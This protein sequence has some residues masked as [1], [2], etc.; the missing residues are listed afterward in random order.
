[1][2]ERHDFFLCTLCINSQHP[3]FQ[4]TLNYSFKHSSAFLPAFC[5]SRSDQSASSPL[6][7]TVTATTI[8]FRSFRPKHAAKTRG[9]NTGQ[10]GRP[11]L[12]LPANARK[13]TQL[14][15]FRLGCHGLPSDV[16]RH[17]ADPLP[18]HERLCTGAM[19]GGETKS[20]WFSSVQHF[21]IFGTSIPLCLLGTI[22]CDPS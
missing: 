20:T 17:R 21:S 13:V 9:Q 6:S 2:T 16:G 10:G 19:P 22:P 7:S 12:Q 1:M 4:T 15:R 5:V 8:T 11:F 18:R 3:K 14:L